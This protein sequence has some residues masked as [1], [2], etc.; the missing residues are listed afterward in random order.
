MMGCISSK[1]Y[2]KSHDLESAIVLASQTSFT[3]NEVEALYGLYKKLSSIIVNDGLIHKEELQLALLGS[4][5]RQNL[6]VDR[7]FNL[8]DL[9]QNGAIEFGDFVQSL[10]IFHPS[11]PL[12]R[13]AAFAFDLYDPQHT[14]YIER[15]E[16][17]KMVLAILEEL[18]LTL[19]DD[20]V[21]AILDKT[22]MEADSKQDGRIDH[23]EWAE[24]VDKN[25]SV[26]KI[27]TL[28]YLRDISTT[29]LSFLID[30]ELQ[31][32]DLGVT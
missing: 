29:F 31:D 25:P 3:V 28:P 11:T 32:S 24:F 16:L 15:V 10:S 19:L 14:G 2:G 13:K 21:E 22:F 4:S 20:H 12:D 23:E 1:K 9:K 8:F 17:K 26:V 5:I 6:F 27:M 18:N 30:T 7:L